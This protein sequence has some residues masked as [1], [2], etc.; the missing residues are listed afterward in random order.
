MAIIAVDVAKSV[1]EVG[2]SYHPGHV[3][4]RH[5]F[6]RPQFSRFIAE[7][8]PSTILIEACGTAHFWGRYAEGFGHRVVLLPPHSV[9]PYVT[10]NKTDRSDVD[11]L[12]EA[13]RNQQIRPVPVK[14]V[15]QQTIASLH[16]LRSTWMATRTAR[17]NTVRGLLRE[18]GVAIPVGARQVLVRLADL[19][20]EADGP[21][22]GALQPALLEVAEEIRELERRI[23]MIEKSLAAIAERTP[24]VERLL[25]I[26]GIGVL[27][28]TALY[29]HVGD[30]LRFASSRRFAS[31][32]GLTPREH[33]SGHRR[34]LGS[35]SK[36]GNSYLRM[37][38][39]HGARSV[40]LQARRIPAP[41]PLH[42]WGLR[43]AQRRGHNKATVAVANKL[44]R[45][46]W[47]VWK[48]D[49]AFRAAA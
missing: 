34:R 17:L 12:L 14:T 23:R 42:A 40:L 49:N 26:P 2:I 35:I 20:A 37:L 11:G 7:T 46:V 13:S 24:V 31:H 29:A 32:L 30:V 38:L 19:R 5:R 6:S 36:Q 45:I 18:L 27:T 4:R 39:T 9:R 21:I 28:A 43:I 1:F 3:S 41:P 22:P 25:T 16:R 33:S 15:A 8:Q 48:K 10:R 44:A 47:A